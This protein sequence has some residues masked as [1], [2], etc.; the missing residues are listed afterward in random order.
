VRALTLLLAVT[1]VSMV[2][3][4]RYELGFVVNPDGSGTMS[5]LVAIS[6]QITAMTGMT[7]EDALDLG[8]DGLP[9]ATVSQYSQDGFTG[10]QMSLPFANLQQLGLFMGGQQTDAIT[11]EFDLRP[12]GS[13][14]WSFATTLAPAAEA[15]G[16]EAAD[17]DALPP[18]LLQGGWARVR[19]QLPGVPAEHNADRIEDGAFVWDID[20]TSSEPRQLTARTTAAGAAEAEVPAKPEDGH[21]ILAGAYDDSTGA[22]TLAAVALATVVVV[23]AARAVT[24]R[25][26]QVRG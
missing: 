11:S 7:T 2:G 26:R 25:R 3:C 19:L 21:G 23:L 1:A 12:D 13:G 4:I 15:A 17:A 6:D 18:E 24:G 9:G 22:S 5:V 8:E 16:P 10:I 14:G 20:L